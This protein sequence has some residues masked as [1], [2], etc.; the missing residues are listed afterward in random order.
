MWNRIAPIILLVVLLASQ[1]V[2]VN[3]FGPVDPL[4]IATALFLLLWFINVF[5]DMSYL[6]PASPLFPACLGL[7]FFMILSGVDVKLG[8]FAVN[9]A[10][11]AAKLILFFLIVNAVRTMAQLKRA[12]SFLVL[13][14][15]ASALLGIG[16]IVLWWQAG[17]VLSL[18][19]ENFRYAYTPWGPLLRASGLARTAQQFDY[20]LIVAA[21][22]ALF[23]AFRPEVFSRRVRILFGIA[24]FIMV[25]A[26]VLSASL[27]ACLAMG[28]GMLL[29]IY[30][31]RPSRYLHITGAFCLLGAFSLV[32]GLLGRVLDVA[33]TLRSDSADI[34]I[35]LIQLGIQAMRDHPITGAG[36]GD[37]ARKYGGISDYPVHNALMQAGSEIGIFGGLIFLVIFMLIPARLLLGLL[38]ATTAEEKAVAEAMLIG[39]APQLLFMQ[40]EPSAWSQ[41][42]WIYFALCEAAFLVL[43]QKYRGYRGPQ[44]GL[45]ARLT[46]RPERLAGAEA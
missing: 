19:S 11:S 44:P 7:L 14:N 8:R 41:A 9:L 32:T 27:G 43:W 16:F 33:E 18:T 21:P 24:S 29:V 36:I 23:L 25:A 37:F 13:A 46:P 26:I 12:I 10:A 34:R 17:L 2:G 4:A 15:V 31:V 1:C 39:L 6:I 22:L 5:S 3:I 42:V 38:N 45:A 20:P 28:L 40:S 35:M 30:R